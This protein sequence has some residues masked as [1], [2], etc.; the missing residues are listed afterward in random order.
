ME[1][2]DPSMG[3]A[4]GKFIPTKEFS[5]YKSHATQIDVE[6]L[7]WDNLS[8][9]TPSGDVLKCDAV[10]LAQYDISLTPSELD[11][12]LEVSCL[13][14]SSPRYEILFPHHIKDYENS[15]KTVS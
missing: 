13:G 11:F 14:I 8:A 1:S 3:V 2:G 12:Y 5:S 10:S 4:L 15:L 6:T 9:S 7:H